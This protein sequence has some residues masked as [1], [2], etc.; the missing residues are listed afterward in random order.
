M[1][2]LV[3][4]LCRCFGEIEENLGLYGLQKG[5]EKHP[6]VSSVFKRESLCMEEDMDWMASLIGETASSTALVAACSLLAKGD[7]ILRG[8]WKRGISPSRLELVDLREGC[9]WIHTNDEA[10]ASRKAADLVSMGLEGLARKASTL[11]VTGPV[12]PTA[13]VIGAG[14]AGLAAASSLARMGFKVHLV[15]KSERPGGLLHHISRLYP[16]NRSSSDLLGPFLQDL[17]NHPLMA[18]HPGSQLLS[19]RGAAG[20]FEVTV[21]GA[22]R[23]MTIR[24]GAVVLAT[25]AGLFLPEGLYRYGDLQNVV[26]QMELE[27]KLTEGTF[28]F[29]H[30]V[31]VQ[32]VGARS[33]E[34]PYCSTVCC[35]ATLKNALRIKEVLPDA[36]VTVLHRDIMTPGR[37]LE[38]GYRR[39]MG[40]G[41]RF[42]RF[43]A[44]DPPV[45]H[46]NGRAETVCVQDVVSG[47]E[48]RIQADMVVLSTPLVPRP[49][50]AKLSRLLGVKLDRHGFYCGGDPSHP[51]ETSVGGV[52]LSGSGRW[53]VSAEQ[54]VMQG[55]AAAAKAAILLRQKEIV[56]SYFDVLPGLPSFKAEVRP[57]LCSGCG[58]CV[59][60]CPFQA[61][62]L[63]NREGVTVSVVDALKCRGCGSCMAVCHTHAIQ[64]PEQNS[65]AMVEKINHAFESV[66]DAPGFPR[67]LVFAC[68]WCSLIGADE[69]GRMKI[70]IPSSFRLIPVECAGRVESEFV[71]RAFVNGMDG[72]AVL[73]CHQGG[74]RYERANHHAARS[75]DS[76]KAFLDFVGIGGER[77]LLNWGEAHEAHQF[78]GLLSGFMA[79]LEALPPVPIKKEL[80]KWLA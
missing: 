38:D 53:P 17:K 13:L 79:S 52:F 7:T 25:G 4:F 61:C 30:A 37:V 75:L 43:H 29:H 69:A 42:I 36:A 68:R 51:L 59:A 44:D 73:G 33:P 46:G 48:R 18:F 35:P 39:A 11:P 45:I 58:D 32:C 22:A 26:T 1:A 24:V 3:V 64:I 41:I 21:G 28:S 20:N 78:V 63:E 19:M 71:I 55:E 60:V 15:E 12:E 40:E 9:A 76:L 50:H 2:R 47:K 72:V 66:K 10:G 31:F 5:L 6:L 34:R 70:V 57:A 77:L 67:V 54:A 80:R 27:K 14:P 23:E 56:P 16:D 8:L 62:H 65:Y 49:D 74:C